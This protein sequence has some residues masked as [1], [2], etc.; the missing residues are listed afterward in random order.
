MAHEEKGICVISGPW[1][2]GKTTAISSFA[3]SHA[4]QCAIVKVEQG[5]MKRG[6]S[7]VLLLQQTV[8]AVRPLI[9][10]SASATL[11]NAYWSLRQ[12]LYNHLVEWRA[13]RQH[14]SHLTDVAQFS[15]VFDE[16]QYLSREA[17][18][19]MRYWND[20]DTATSPFPVALHF[21]GNSEFA[22]DSSKADESVLS[23]AVRSRALFIETMGYEDVSDRDISDYIDSRGAYD[24]EAKALLLQHFSG[25]RVR[26]DFRTLARLDGSL[27]RR[28]QGPTIGPEDVLSLVG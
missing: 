14:S 17:I 22:L 20:A 23:G 16:A 24:D 13:D 21:L 18:E 27:R 7:P 5:S 9:G 6:A 8:E 25:R 15:I 11:S 26:R 12:M 19:M 1:G 2:I 4:G 3:Q 28:S 10:R